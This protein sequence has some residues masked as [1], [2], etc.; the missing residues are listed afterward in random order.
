MK[1]EIG[2]ILEEDEQGGHYQTSQGEKM[3]ETEP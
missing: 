1:L 3:I 2:L